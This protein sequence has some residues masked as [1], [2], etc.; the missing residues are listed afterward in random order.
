MQINQLKPFR[1][2]TDENEQMVQWEAEALKLRMD[3]DG[4]TV[5]MLTGIDLPLRNLDTIWRGDVA[6]TGRSLAGMV[7]PV[8]KTIPEILLN[9][10][11]FLGRD[12]T[13]TQSGAVGRLLDNDVTPKAVKDWLGYRKTTNEAGKPSYTFDGR[14]FTL[15]FRSWAL[16]RAVS[17]S[18]R[19]FREYLDGDNF[20]WQRAMLDV[21]TGIRRKDVDMDEQMRRKAFNRI[22]Q[23][24]DSLARRGRLQEFRKRFRGK[25][26]GEF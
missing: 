4:K 6:R 26:Q 12:M 5:H 1:G 13:R 22:R 20:A 21:M 9:Q 19:Q 24:E 3:R 14:R 25:Q 15:L 11:F 10:D 16:S 7:T 17:T 8:L 18:D 23:L 2:R